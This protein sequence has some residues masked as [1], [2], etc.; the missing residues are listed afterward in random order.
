MRDQYKVLAEKYETIAED[1]L[2][3]FN[4]VDVDLLERL[5]ATD[6]VEEFK[7]LAKKFDRRHGPWMQMHSLSSDDRHWLQSTIDKIFKTKTKWSH[8]W[9]HGDE[10]ETKPQVLFYQ[11]VYYVFY[12]YYETRY[13]YYGPTNNTTQIFEKHLKRWFEYKAAK[14]LQQK[15]KETGI[16]LDI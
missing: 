6:S 12:Y 2:S 14:A 10:N 3:D 5:A 16:N 7:E 1:N 11:T 4:E 8:V 15:N 13:A 9:I